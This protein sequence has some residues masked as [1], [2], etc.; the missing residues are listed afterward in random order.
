MVN[1]RPDR[2]C[3]L[4]EHP[5]GHL[6]TSLSVVANLF[7]GDA[8]IDLGQRMARVSTQPERLEVVSRRAVAR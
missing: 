1:S 7:G 4:V 3:M 5:P 6:V 2:C 8:R